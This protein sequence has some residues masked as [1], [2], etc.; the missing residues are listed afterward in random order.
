MQKQIRI[1]LWVAVLFS[2]FCVITTG[3]QSVG[4]NQRQGGLIGAGAGSLIGA[5]IGSTDGKALEGA[6]IGGTIGATIGALEGRQ[7][8]QQNAAYQRELQAR[9]TH[10]DQVVQMTR[11][12]LSEEV[13]INQIRSTGIVSPPTHEQLIF[14]KNNGVSDRVIAAMQGAGAVPQYA[15][16]P[17]QPA[18]VV[19]HVWVEPRWYGPRRYRRRR[20][21]PPYGPRRSVGFS[22]GF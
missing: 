12:G 11:S 7:V 19:E 17:T 21:C 18:T 13:I 4:P 14:L 6:G 1:N 22:F 2:A 5:A 9:A 20:P 3:C 8:D 10:I 15:P 16:I